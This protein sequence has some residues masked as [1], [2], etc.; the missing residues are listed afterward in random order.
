MEKKKARTIWMIT[1]MVAMIALVVATTTITDTAIITTGYGRFGWTDFLEITE[2]ATPPADTLRWYVIE[3]DGFSRINYKDEL[4]VS[5]TINDDEIIVNNS[6]GSTIAAHRFVYTTGH[7]SG[8]PTVNLAKADNISTMPA[9][10]VTIES[11]SDG[12]LGRCMMSGLIEDVNTNAFD[13]GTIYVSDATA[14]IPTN[15]APITPNLTQEMGTI[16]VKSTTVGAIQIIA[17]ALT[18][19]E[20]GTINNFIIA[21]NLTITSEGSLFL[22]ANTTSVTCTAGVIYYDSTI[23]KHMACNGTWNEMY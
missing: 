19:D 7:D 12:Q 18:G 9:I 23:N 10:C 8:I 4:G 6:R 21:K 5:R 16:L 22:T 3:Q 2:P 11:I 1:G 20:F 15:T 17:R 14:G 13:V